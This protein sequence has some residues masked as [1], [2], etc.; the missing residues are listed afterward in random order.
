MNALYRDVEAIRPEDLANTVV[1]IAGQ[2][3]HVNI[4]SVEI[5]PVAQSYAALNIARNL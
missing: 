5:M 4:N 2:P 1:W 3:P